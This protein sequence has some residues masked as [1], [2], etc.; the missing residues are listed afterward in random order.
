[1]RRCQSLKPGR[2]GT[3][4]APVDRWRSL[5]DVG[6]TKGNHRMIPPVTDDLVQ[7]GGGG[8]VY[9]YPGVYDISVTRVSEDTEYSVDLFRRA[10]RIDLIDGS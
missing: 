6:A 5:G 8:V 7:A 4:F 1:M 2:K 3:L 9:A 10:P